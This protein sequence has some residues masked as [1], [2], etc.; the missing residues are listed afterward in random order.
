[1]KTRA[2][3]TIIGTTTCLCCG[4]K[5]P[6]KLSETGTLDVSCGWCDLPTYAKAGT[7]SHKALMA[8]VVRAANHEVVDAHPA[9]VPAESQAVEKPAARAARSFFDLSRA[10][11]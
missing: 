5:I 7:A 10:G 1:M 9:Q 2:K 8:R 11:A 6:A 3:K 4:E